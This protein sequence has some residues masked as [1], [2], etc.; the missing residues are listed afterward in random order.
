M[1]REVKGEDIV[2]Y[3]SLCGKG[4]KKRS[5]VMRTGIL[6]GIYERNGRNDGA[7]IPSFQCFQCTHLL[8]QGWSFRIGSGS[9]TRL[10]VPCRQSFVNNSAR[11][12][13]VIEDD[14]P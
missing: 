12:L 11:V 10:S 2:M 4:W 6:R 3:E 9:R 5:R 14:A 8:R 1:G 7:L 13:R